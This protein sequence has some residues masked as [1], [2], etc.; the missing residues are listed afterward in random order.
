MREAEAIDAFDRAF[1]ALEYSQPTPA[2]RG[3]N[4]ERRWIQLR[5]GEI[6]WYES[7]EELA[8]ILRE[9]GLL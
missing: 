9:R 5:A 3:R 7:D 6:L 1:A 8:G 2:W 4:G